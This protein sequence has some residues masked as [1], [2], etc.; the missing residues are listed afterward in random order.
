MMFKQGQMRKTWQIIKKK[1]ANIFGQR[2]PHKWMLIAAVLLTLMGFGFRLH[3]LSLDS[4]WIDELI[5]IEKS[6]G[7]IGRILNVRDHPPLLYFLT[8]ASIFTFGETEF[9]VRLPS[10]MVGLLTVPLLI[11]FGRALNRPLAGILAAILIILSPFNM[12]HAQEARHYSLLLTFSLASYL[13]LYMA[14]KKPSFIRWIGFG[15]ATTLNLYSHYGAFIVLTVQSILI[16]GWSLSMII[17]RH[18]R[19]LLFPL[20]A[21]F[22]VALLYIIQLPRLNRAFNRTFVNRGFVTFNT[23]ADLMSWLKNLY[24]A[25]STNSDLLAPVLLALC[26]IGIAILF[27]RRDWFSFTFCLLGL[28]LPLIVILI[29]GVDRTSNPRYMIYLLPFYMLSVAIALSEFLSWLSRRVGAGPAVVGLVIVIII[30]I[31]VSLPIVQGEYDFAHSYMRNIVQTLNEVGQNG[32]IILAVSLSLPSEVNLVGTQLNYYLD[33]N[34]KHFHL[35]EANKISPG[36][37]D[38][39]NLI[40]DETDNIW[41]VVGYWGKTNLAGQNLDVETQQGNFY[42]IQDTSAKGTILERILNIYDKILP[43]AQTPFPHCILKQDIALIYQKTGQIDSASHMLDSIREECP[44]MTD[45]YLG[46]RLSVMLEVEQLYRA[47]EEAQTA[48]TVEEVRKLA[49]AIQPH[50]PQDEEIQAYLKLVDLL[51]FFDQGQA[52]IESKALEPVS[53]ASFGMPPNNYEGDVLLLHPPSRVTYD[54]YL[55]EDPTVFRTRI[56]MVPDSWEWGGDGSTFVIQLRSEDG[57]MN[58]LLRQHISNELAERYWHPV[59]IPLGNYAG[60]RVSL[61]LQTE[62]GPVG[63]DTGDWAI[64]DRPGIWWETETP[65]SW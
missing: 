35:I 34:N 64:W 63:S 19:N 58:E 62:S 15:L 56:A 24:P 17:R 61:T 33:K 1:S 8:K 4:F 42:L 2:L 50:N 57:N 38:E 11:A 3:N 7:S 18:Y 39:L 29:T 41:S 59:E 37:L 48:G 23:Q 20:S 27:Y 60:Q 45:P 30:F 32:D 52:N 14:M 21:A 54:L 31:V 22:A 49:A 53:R 46:P 10:A 16:A 44:E 47:F 65:F 43:L 51:E 6:T 13:I 40:T 25:L 5:T 26:L 55:P 12:R 9:T 36:D 28:G